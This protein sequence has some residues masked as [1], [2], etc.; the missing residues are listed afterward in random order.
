[1]KLLDRLEEAN[2]QDKGTE[3][4]ELNYVCDIIDVAKK[5][6]M[7]FMVITLT[8]WGKEIYWFE[9]YEEAKSFDPLN[10]YVVQI[11]STFDNKKY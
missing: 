6:E 11:V 7:N 3:T 10:E 1:M 5:Q 4:T 2:Y 8:A 9:T